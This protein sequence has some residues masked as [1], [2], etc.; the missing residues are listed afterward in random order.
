MEIINNS[1]ETSDTDYEE[2]DNVSQA[3]EIPLQIAE[4]QEVASKPRKAKKPHYVDSNWKLQSKILAF[5]HMEPPHT[6][7]E[8]ALK[9]LEMFNDWGIEKKIFSI[10][11]D[12]A[13]ANDTMQK[14]LK[15]H[16]EISNS[17]LLNGEYFHIRCS[18]HVLNLIVQDG[19]KI[20]SDA[21]HKIK[22]SVGYCCPTSVEWKRVETLCDLL[23]PFYNITNLISGSS[24]P[25]SNLYFG[26]IWKIECLLRSY[27][28]SEDP[29][30]Q[31]MTTKIKEKFDK[32]WSEYSVILA[33]ATILDPTKKLK[34]VRYAY[35]KLDPLTSEDKSKSVKMML[36]KLCA[37]YVNNEIL[38]SNPSSSQQVVQPPSRRLASIDE[39]EFEEFENQE[40]TDIGK[41]ELVA[42]LDELRMPSSACFDIL[43]YWK[44]KRRK[45]PTLVRI[46]C[47][48]LSIPI[49]TVASESAFSISARVLTKYRS[50]MKDESIQAILCARS[51]LYGF[52]EL[53]DVNSNIDKDDETRGSVQASNTVEYVNI[54]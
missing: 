45:S 5:A 49:T 50:S 30:I 27:L 40:T 2:E 53:D 46:A 25:T 48:I 35:S 52:E 20:V 10:T 22:Q 19:L 29:L 44:E 38:Y 42:Y 17:L 33:F 18:A 34:F 1:P 11:L 37:E 15:E 6:G 47:D 4:E 24:Y 41:T 14:F 3:R 12:N 28:T 51:W 13:S 32:Y 26:E 7:R 36:E 16:L 9:V 23:K 54:D 8:L 43:A 39:L 31:N 21:L